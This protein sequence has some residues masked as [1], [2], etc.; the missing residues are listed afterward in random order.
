LTTGIALVFGQDAFTFPTQL[1]ADFNPGTAS[2][3]PH[4]LTHIERAGKAYGVLQFP[5][6]FID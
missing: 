6:M 3:V 5:G 1:L 4:H 2:S